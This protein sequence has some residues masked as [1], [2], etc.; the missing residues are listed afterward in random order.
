MV[1]I[2]AHRPS[3]MDRASSGPY[4]ASAPHRRSAGLKTPRAPTASEWVTVV[5]TPGSKLLDQPPPGRPDRLKPAGRPT[6][7]SNPRR[8]ETRWASQA[9]VETENTTRNRNHR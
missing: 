5:L 2:R 8:S 7:A 4:S 3:E 6:P 1:A 9:V